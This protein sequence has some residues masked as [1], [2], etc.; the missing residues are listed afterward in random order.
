MQDQEENREEKTED[1]SFMKEKIKEKPL[2]KRKIVSRVLLTLLCA[3]IFG[4]VASLVI[5]FLLP[6]LQKKITLE[7]EPE[8][9]V[10]PR[11]ERIPET[12][13]ESESE[14]E[15]ETETEESTEEPSTEEILSTEPVEV[16]DLLPEQQQNLRKQLYAIGEE[17]N[18]FI[19]TVTGVKSDTDW[20]N[21]VYSSED[22][23]SGAIVA[24]TGDEILIVT[25]NKVI[26]GAETVKVTFIDGE[27]TDATLKGAD[28]VTGIAVLTVPVQSV[29]EETLQEI[30]TATLANSLNV[31]EGTTVLAL[32]SPLGTNFTVLTGS[33]TGTGESLF[34]AD[35]VFTVFQTDIITANSGNGVLV[36]LDGEIIG[37]MRKENAS[38]GTIAAIS[39]SELK[40]LLEKLENGLE[41]PYL[42]LYI[43]TVTKSIAD[44]YDL[45]QGVFI[46]SVEMD[47][48]GMEANLLSGDVIVEM[49]GIKV[50][51]AE[52]YRT[53]LFEHAPGDTI[54]IVIERLGSEGY[55]KVSCTATVGTS[56]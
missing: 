3:V 20:F 27:T 56:E 8:M 13:S 33:I 26:R 30:K 42:G 14:T 44:E 22:K 21:A 29:K 47:S 1:F 37:F 46:N 31:T 11:D 34:L 2:N 12:E 4:V 16:A 10:I 15:P 23:A 18:R 39:V 40:S 48:P 54:R 17:A 50:T 36:N 45:P 55:T 35:A 52:G 32:G 51:D 24:N 38:V 41:V 9:I 49:D 6:R 43:S 7:E 19:V 25:E 28:G 5:A 53:A